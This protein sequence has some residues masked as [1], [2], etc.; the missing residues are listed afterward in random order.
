[1][2][3]AQ[4][5]QV[6]QR[7]RRGSPQTTDSTHRHGPKDHSP[8]QALAITLRPRCVAPAVPRRQRASAQ[9]P[10]PRWQPHNL[11][12]PWHRRRGPNPAPTRP[13]PRRDNQGS[14]PRPTARRDKTSRD[15]AR[16][17]QQLRKPGTGARSPPPGKPAKRL[18]PWPSQPTRQRRCESLSH[19]KCL[20][21]RRPPSVAG[22][23]QLQAPAESRR[24]SRQGEG[25]RGSSCMKYRQGLRALEDN[26]VWQ[27][28]QKALT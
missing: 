23:G 15:T 6:Q 25:P 17:A 12:P 16:V 13:P 1:M 14:H 27:I 5:I 22:P 2:G 21:G 19:A 24:E 26:P 11:K 20:P 10:H 7:L 9:R 28:P 3:S 8:A 4:S 18:P